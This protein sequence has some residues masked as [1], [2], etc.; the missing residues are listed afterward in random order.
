MDRQ[1][2]LLCQMLQRG[3]LPTCRSNP[4]VSL[5]QFLPVAG[6]FSLAFLLR[7]VC[8]YVEIP[9]LDIMLQLF[10]QRVR[11]KKL[12]V[13]VFHRGLPPCSS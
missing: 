8:G 5:L 2:V 3:A 7:L 11:E 6:F 13:D 10:Y 9:T 1:T 4:A 12:C